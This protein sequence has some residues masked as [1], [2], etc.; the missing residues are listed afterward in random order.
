MKASVDGE[1]MDAGGWKLTHDLSAS[2][3][4]F[5]QHDW[6]GERGCLE[7]RGEYI[8]EKVSAVL[9]SWGQEAPAITLFSL[10]SCLQCCNPLRCEAQDRNPGVS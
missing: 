8:S 9:A 6:G 3:P 5:W 4:R 1:R 2:E 7:G 10:G